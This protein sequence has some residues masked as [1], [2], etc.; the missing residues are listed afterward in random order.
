MVMAEMPPLYSPLH[1]VIQPHNP[2][3]DVQPSRFL[4]PMVATGS[5]RYSYFDLSQ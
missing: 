3:G 2:M 5:R 4:L 1:D